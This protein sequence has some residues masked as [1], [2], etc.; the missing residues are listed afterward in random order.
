MSVTMKPGRDRVRGD[1]EL[2]QLDRERL[3]EPLQPGLRRRVVRLPAV[4]QRRRA[5]Q[6][7]DPAPLR[8]GH[9]LLHRPGHEERAAQVHVH[10]DVPVGVGHLEQQVV[11]GDPGVVHQHDRR[12]ELRGDPVDGGLHLLGVAD[13][14]AHGQ[15]AAAGGL[16][17]L[18]PCR[19]RRPRSGR[20][21]RR[22]TRRR[23]A[24]RA[25][26]APMPRAAPVTIATRPS[27]R[28]CRHPL[29]H[30]GQALAAADAHRLQ[31]VAGLAAVHLAQQRGEDPA[32]GRA[33]RVAEGDARAV[34]VDAVEVGCR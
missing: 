31:A 16:D 13:V 7:D 23:P 19:G 5:R 28:S 32:A 6:V 10:D 17:R 15:R 2:A 24:A 25:V 8:L 33:D 18:A 9:V 30:R 3:G 12:A 11:A 22:R 26:A 34:D 14:G 20:A 4:A 1:P 29:E 21:P 27:A